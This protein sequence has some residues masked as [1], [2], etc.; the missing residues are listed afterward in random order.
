M[1]LLGLGTYR[2][3]D[4]VTS[5]TIAAAA[6]CPLIDTAPVYGHGTHQAAISPVLRAHPRMRIATK[7]GHM[8]AD[9]AR[10]ALYSRVISEAEALRRHSIAPDYVHYQV[11]MNCAEVQ[12]DQLDLVYLHNPEHRHS[13]DRDALLARLRSAFVALED[14]RDTGTV[15]GYG[16]ATWNGF[17][18]GAFSVRELVKL[19]EEASGGGEAGLR[20]IQLP[21]SMVEIGPIRQAL[22]GD[23][24]IPAAGQAGL[25][26]WGSAPLHGGELLG[27]INEGL[28]D[29]VAFG[30]TN[31]QAALM[32]AVSTPGL[33][34]LLLS[35]G[36]ADHWREAADVVDSPQLPPLRLKEICDL[37]QPVS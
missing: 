28:A 23:G 30:A 21:V 37:L 35:T 27:R 36:S 15:L 10:A 3:R 32:V 9:Q 34:G 25:E 18:D 26:V 6:G 4:A 22:A 7:V 1:T 29:Y 14:L 33:T 24:P 17:R 19:A 13:G 12:R 2:S 11:A 8:T 31:A 20:A 5:A 16:V